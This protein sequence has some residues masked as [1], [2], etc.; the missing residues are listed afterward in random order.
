M[1]V[2]GD[3]G[4]GEGREGRSRLMEERTGGKEAQVRVIRCRE[5][6]EGRGTSRKYRKLC[7]VERLALKK[8]MA[9]RRD[10]NER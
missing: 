6:V 7:Q 1:C 8:K 9:K 2:G 10:E 3:K 4:S 5:G